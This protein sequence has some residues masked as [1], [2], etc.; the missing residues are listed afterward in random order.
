M[1]IQ[2]ITRLIVLLTFTEYGCRPE[3]EKKCFGRQFFYVSNESK[4]VLARNLEECRDNDKNSQSVFLSFKCI[5][6]R[7]CEGTEQLRKINI[8]V[9]RKIKRYRF[10]QRICIF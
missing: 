8:T 9:Q 4:S 1:T 5:F 6:A 3:H 7:N 10:R 2:D